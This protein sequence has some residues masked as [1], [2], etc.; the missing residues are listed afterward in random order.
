MTSRLG[1]EFRAAA[2][3]H[4]AAVR[5]IAAGLSDRAAHA[6]HA[7]EEGRRM[8]GA[9]VAGFTRWSGG[10]SDARQR[11]IGLRTR[12]EAERSGLDGAL[13]RL[14]QEWPA[15]R[16]RLVIPLLWMRVHV[17]AILMTLALLAGGAL[18]LL[19]WPEID[20]FLRG[21]MASLEGN[22]PAIAWAGR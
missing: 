16:L 2:A 7:R 10:L 22:A 3:R 21:L 6:R 14:P 13:R 15:I 11:L 1:D 4:D 19:F 5:E 9:L 20:M 8:G 18:M 17:L 12:V